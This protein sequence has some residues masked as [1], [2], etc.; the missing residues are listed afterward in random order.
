MGIK[1]SSIF[2][3]GSLGAINVKNVKKKSIKLIEK[4]LRIKLTKKII[5]FTYH[6]TTLHTKDDI[7]F[8]YSCLNYFK[9]SEKF[10]LIIS[11]PNEDH[12]RK[13][14]TTV[15][16][17]FKKCKNFIFVKNL[18]YENY[19][20]LLNYANIMIGNSSS[21]IIEAASYNLPVLNLGKRQKGRLT[22]KNVINLENFNEKKLNKKLDFVTN[23]N[24]KIKK[25]KNIYLNSKSYSKIAKKISKLS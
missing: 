13:N 11:N 9:N 16:N 24:F 14:I 3:T 2:K 20:N 25:I 18:G 8:V 7:S 4:E 22:S 17:K 21:G 23:N 12:S 6:T 19:A 1:S 10:Q 15:Y 5:L